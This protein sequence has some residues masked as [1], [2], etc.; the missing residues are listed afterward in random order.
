MGLRL[1]RV[2]GGV[3]QLVRQVMCKVIILL[4]LFAFSLQAADLPAPILFDKWSVSSDLMVDHPSPVQFISTFTRDQLAQTPAW[5]QEREHPPLAPRKAEDL[6][7]AMLRKIAGERRWTQPDISLRAFDVTQGG[8]G[9]R[10]IRWIY[11][12]QFRL[13]GTMDFESGS[14]NIIVFMD[15]TVIEPRRVD[16]KQ[17]LLESK[18]TWEYKVVQRCDYP[19]LNNKMQI[20]Y[21]FPWETQ[22][23]LYEEQ[24]WSIDSVAFA[25][26]GFGKT[27]LITLK[28][29]KK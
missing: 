2:A 29:A 8:S 16:E 25:T 22:L 13:M 1:A 21:A 12:L 3:A 10:E 9:Q 14:V 20:V 11:V 4:S 5:P 18:N 26:N 17:L 28:H 23:R 27:A 7:L 19:G 15:G 24:G 6:A